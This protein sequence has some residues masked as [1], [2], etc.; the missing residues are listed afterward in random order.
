MFGILKRKPVEP[1][2]EP[3]E[4]LD[5]QWVAERENEAI[6]TPDVNMLEHRMWQALFLSGEDMPGSPLYEAFIKPHV[7][8]SD[9]KKPAIAFTV[10]R[11][12]VYQK[13]WQEAE[14]DWCK[15]DVVIVPLDN[16]FY[17]ENHS[18]IKGY[19]VMISPKGLYAL[20]NHWRNTVEFQRRRVSI[21]IPQTRY[22]W[23]KAAGSMPP[24]KTIT[25]R[26]AWFYVGNPKF[27]DSHLDQGYSSH[28]LEHTKSRSYWME[29]YIFYDPAF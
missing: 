9:G 16:K 14:G 22:R 1:A 26:K 13:T 19:L 8:V 4:D 23:T 15:G 20:D 6:Y 24:E 10:D 7:H 21:T 25:K 17:G 18:C 27:W 12:T 11:F 2:T 29:D 3:V 28:A 5:M